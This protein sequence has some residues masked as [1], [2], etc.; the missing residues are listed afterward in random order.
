M[1]VDGMQEI[2]KRLSQLGTK[3]NRTENKA[4]RAGGN[5]LAE[6]MSNEVPV[7]D[8]NHEHIRDNIAVSG[9]KRSTGI[10]NVEVGPNK[11]V[12]WRAHFLEFGT[13]K[14]MPNPFI[15]RSASVS[16]NDVNEAIRQELK[17]GLGL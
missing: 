10:P 7:S 4:I 5:I 16:K 15:S 13:I 17:K 11:E 8:V 6:T 1:E 9:V 2:Q 3:R 14:M 12:A